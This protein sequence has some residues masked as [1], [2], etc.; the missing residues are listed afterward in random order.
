MQSPSDPL[1]ESL[2]QLSKLLGRPT[3]AAALTA[4]LPLQN[5]VLT[6]ELFIR[7]AARAELSAQLSCT[8]IS[9]ISPLSLPVVLLLNNGEAAILTKIN[10]KKAEILLPTTGSGGK[11]VQLK[12]LKKDYSGRMISVAPQLKLDSRANNFTQK[13]PKQWFWGTLA[14]SWPVYSEV[15]IASLLLNLF[16]VAMPLFVMN[17]YDR[18]VPNS[19]LDT[20]MVLALGVGIIFTFDFLLRTLRSYF[21]DTSGKRAD[22]LLSSHIFE[23]VM[24]LRME[25]LP[26]SSGA[27]ANNL[28]EFET[29]RDFF[30]S[31][32][33]AALID[34]PFI[35]LFIWVISLIGGE[36]AMI[37]LVAVPIVI[38]VGILLQIPL[39]KIIQQ[40]FRESS[41][42]H[43][44]LVEAITSLEAI[45]SL[46]AEGQLQQRWEEIVAALSRT[47]MKSRFLS[48]LALNFSTLAQQIVSVLVVITGVHAIVEGELTMGALIACTLLT[49]RALAP[50]S[51]IASILTRYH[52][53]ITAL[54]S[55]N[56][57]MELPVERTSEQKFLNRPAIKGDITLKDV[58]FAYPGQDGKALDNISLQ[59]KSGEKIAIIGRIGSGKSTIERMITGLYQA[60][61][62]S[63]MIDSTDIR[64]I[65]PA[66]LRRNIGF[67]PQ[68]VSLFHGTLRENLALGNPFADDASILKAASLTGV[69]KLAAQH[70]Q[71][72]D[73]PIGERGIGL[74][75]GQKQTVAIARAL[76]SDPQ[77]ILLD[78][79]TNAMDNSTEASFKQQLEPTLKGKTVVIVSHRASL[80]S[81]VDRV[82]VMDAGKIAADGPRDEVVAALSAGKISVQ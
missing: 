46:R 2:V 76:L 77:I 58:S 21:I 60:T 22:I 16:T 62:G 72:F 75:G 80:L 13:R 61:S 5:G 38:I 19:A 4:G 8:R 15:V 26:P 25:A 29:L 44:T 7:A 1:L 51:Q 82:V 74:S 81:I 18:V 70:P 31:A 6:T 10:G 34:L 69:D 57:V 17:V 65:D 79:P 68:D 73:M 52:Q 24:N 20:L 41:M 48:T 78:E 49:G 56:G 67:V 23:Q 33:M 11:L 66:D 55:L 43:A 39:A 27:F 50:L 40:S 64:Q 47:G 32:T 42:K 71:G 3:S 63:V 36:L 45:K 28:R 30:T 53:S 14:K 37:P 35:F 12:E 9:K 59:I 54:K